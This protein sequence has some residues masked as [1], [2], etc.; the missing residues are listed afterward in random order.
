[1]L[2]PFL[3]SVIRRHAYY[4]MSIASVVVLSEHSNVLTLVL[5][6]LLCVAVADAKVKLA[7]VAANMIGFPLVESIAVGLS[8]HTWVYVHP[9]SILPVPP[10]LFP[11]WGLASVWISDIFVL[12]HDDD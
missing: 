1:M 4:A 2:H 7:Y 5:T 3:R 9:L 8:R 11:L 12:V 6:L 10:W